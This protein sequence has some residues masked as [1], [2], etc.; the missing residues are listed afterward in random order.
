LVSVD[1][2]KEEAPLVTERSVEAGGR[3]AD[4]FRQIVDRGRLIAAAPEEPHGGLKG[5]VAIETSR[6]PARLT[7]GLRRIHSEQY[8]IS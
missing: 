6:S 3:D 2:F 7:L 5:L 4:R 1:R 8:K